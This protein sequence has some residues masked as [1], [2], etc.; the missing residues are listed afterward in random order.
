MTL[1]KILAALAVAGA[2][3]AAG[4]GDDDNSSGAKGSTAGGNG[5]DRAF[6]ADMVPHH[7]SAIEMAKIAQDR[8]QSTFVKE[9]ADDIITTQTEEIKVLRR[10]DEGLDTAGFKAGSLG[11]PEHMKGMEGDPAT[12]KT[13]D[14]F[15]GAFLKMMIP[16]HQGAIEMAKAELAKGTDRELKAIASDI[17][18]VQQR[19]IS[20][21]RKHLGDAGASDDGMKDDAHGSGHG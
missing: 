2:L 3:I 1:S 16:H 10:E 19:E 15:D 20:D 8:G 5:A 9:L 17:I 6:V 7:Q 21:M 14:P 18:N 4:C 11:V 13:A 12:L